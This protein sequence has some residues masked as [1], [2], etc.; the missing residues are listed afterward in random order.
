MRHSSQTV[1]FYL[2]RMIF[3]CCI[4]HFIRSGIESKLVC[5]HLVL[6]AAFLLAYMSLHILGLFVACRAE[7]SFSIKS[8]LVINTHLESSKIYICFFFLCLRY[9]SVNF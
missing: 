3:G 4:V 2:A 1:L 8:V 7:R 6:K 5:G 9:G